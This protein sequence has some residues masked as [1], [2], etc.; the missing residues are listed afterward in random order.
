MN[1]GFI[2]VGGVAQPHLQ[3]VS[4]MRGVQISAVCDIVPERVQKVAE[5]YGATSYDNYREMLKNESLDACY[6]CV[7]PGAHG[8]I[9]LD[10][11][12]AKLPFY[13]EKPV[14][15]DLNVC[16]KVIDELEKNGTGQQRRLSLA[17]TR[18]RRKPRRSLSIS[19]RSALLRAG[20]M[21]VSS[22]RRGGAR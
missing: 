11:A 10:L 12:K 2:G 7:I 3:N 5:T 20:G 22:A 6:V 16:Q 8:N 14:H 15:L 4:K 13:A 21:E 19:I 18:A 17:L 9:E 1:I